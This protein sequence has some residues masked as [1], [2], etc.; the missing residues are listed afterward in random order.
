MKT[1]YVTVLALL[2]AGIIATAAAAHPKLVATNPS[3]NAVVTISP[4]AIRLT[5]SEDLNARFSGLELKDKTGKK[6][7]TGSVSFEPG[8]K[9]QLIL[10]IVAPLS[11]G[12]YDVAWHAVASDTHRIEGQYSFTVQQ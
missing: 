2:S 7:E 11:A 6:I 8:N 5:F 4:S 3:A 1:L 12:A 9:K 10:P